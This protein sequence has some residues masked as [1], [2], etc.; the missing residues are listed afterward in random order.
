MFICRM[1]KRSSGDQ[2]GGGSCEKGTFGDPTKDL[3]R[4]N[5]VFDNQS[6]DGQSLSTSVGG[7]ELEHNREGSSP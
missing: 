4:G 1:Q 6:A 3:Q 5:R 2:K 7:T